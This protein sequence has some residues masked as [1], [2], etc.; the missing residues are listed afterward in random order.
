MT[1]GLIR[2]NARIARD[3][4]IYYLDTLCKLPGAY[5]TSKGQ[6][7]REDLS[8]KRINGLADIHAIGQEIEKSKTKMNSIGEWV[9]LAKEG[10]WSKGIK[11]RI[12][13]FDLSA[14]EL[15]RKVELLELDYR[16]FWTSLPT[17]SD[18]SDDRSKITE[19]LMQIELIG[20]RTQD[21]AAQ[22]SK[23][24]K[25]VERFVDNKLS[26]SKKDK[27]E[28]VSVGPRTTYGVYPEQ[29]RGIRVQ[30][31]PLSWSKRSIMGVRVILKQ[32]IDTVKLITLS[33]YYIARIL[34]F[35]I[36]YFILVPAAF[37]ETIINFL[38]KR[39]LGG[40]RQKAC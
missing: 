10:T 7:K 32:V 33:L 14:G 38:K 31:K 2:D 28:Q 34:I 36:K 16:Y 27:R 20:E 18:K 1:G 40:R 35:V 37:I 12:E 15:K 21:L 26:D 39:R 30:D 24:E 6:V 4:M 3:G 5:I 23:L 19:G 8:R 29:G 9:N 25:G 13:R 11:K 22:A 17:A